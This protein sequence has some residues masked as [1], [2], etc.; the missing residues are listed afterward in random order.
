[1]RRIAPRDRPARVALELVPA[2]QAKLARDRKEP[3]GDAL[4]VRARV[5][6]VVDARVVGLADRDGAGI[7]GFEHARADL[8]SDGVDLLDDVDHRM[9]LSFGA[10]VRS[11]ESA[12]PPTTG[13]LGRQ[14]FQ[15]R[16]PET[17]EPVEP[18]VDVAQRGCVHG[19]EAPGALG[20]H[21]GEAAV[22]QDAEVLRDARLRDPE[23]GLDGRADRT[24]GHLAVG[25]QFEDPPTHRVAEHI[26]CVHPAIYIRFCLY[27]S[28]RIYARLRSRSR[29]GARRASAPRRRAGRSST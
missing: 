5:P 14:R 1:M 19:V 7:A 25:E 12:R 2:V 4:G 11:C 18:R 8:P 6:D 10:G 21:A 24:G 16:G 17:P 13:E 26:E 29:A 9:L 23:V 15:G 3:A 28:S 20:P 22:A 27:K